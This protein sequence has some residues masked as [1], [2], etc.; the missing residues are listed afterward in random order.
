MRRYSGQSRL[1]TENTIEHDCG[2]AHEQFE[3]L[4]FQPTIAHC[5]PLEMAEINDGRLLLVIGRRRQA[6]SGHEILPGGPAFTAGYDWL[7][8]IGT[9]TA[10]NSTTL[11]I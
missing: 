7:A 3:D 10:E 1:R 4:T 11:C 5:H 9:R 6:R 2:L 8:A